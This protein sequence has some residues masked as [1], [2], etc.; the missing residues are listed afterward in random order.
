LY[1]QRFDRSEKWYPYFWIMI[2]VGSLGWY[3]LKG[4]GS[5]KP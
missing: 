4:N 2:L 5:K 1:A 3:A